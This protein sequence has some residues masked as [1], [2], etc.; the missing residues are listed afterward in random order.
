MKIIIQ[1]SGVD[2]FLE[3][4]G[5]K[6]FLFTYISVGMKYGVVISDSK[7]VTEHILNDLEAFRASEFYVSKKI[8]LLK[9]LN[10][11]DNCIL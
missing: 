4:L 6:L 8:I 2:L 5:S 10:K 11:L 9:G 7:K 1:D 3:K